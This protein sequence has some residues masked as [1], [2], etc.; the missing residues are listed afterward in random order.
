MKRSSKYKV[1]QNCEKLLKIIFIN[2]KRMFLCLKEINDFV[3]KTEIDKLF[4]KPPITQK[5]IMKNKEKLSNVKEK[6]FYKV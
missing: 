1:K 3:Y 5:K 4:E 2:L 6:L